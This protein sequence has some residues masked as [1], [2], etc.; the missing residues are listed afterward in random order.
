M[1]AFDTVPAFDAVIDLGPGDLAAG[2]TREATVAAAAS[3]H[4]AAF[5]AAKHET[6]RFYFA[7]ILPRT[8]AHAAAM[9]SGIDTLMALDADAFDAT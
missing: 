7:R 8:D 1:P 9:T 2:V 3:M 5:K 4:T 6:A